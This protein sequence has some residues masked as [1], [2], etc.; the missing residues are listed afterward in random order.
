MDTSPRDEAPRRVLERMRMRLL[1]L[2][3]RNPLLNYTHPRASS[4][5]IVD[6][7]PTVVLD[8]LIANRTYRFAPLKL[9]DAPAPINDPAP[10]GFVRANGGR[11]GRSAN[12]VNTPPNATTAAVATPPPGVEIQPPVTERERR[13][14][15]R[16]ARAQREEQIRAGATAL[17][18][19]PSYDLLAAPASDATRH[20]D[21]R[22]Q[23]LLTPDELE[24]RLQKM[25]A[26]AVTAIQ[27]SGANMLHLLF[28]FVEW[29]DVAGEKTRMAPL[30][31]LP[32]TMSR[33]ALDPATHTYPYTVAASG[34]DWST[35]VT[36]Q[37]MC[38]KSFGFAL[39]S[40]EP[41]EDL[42]QYFSRVEE[43][44]RVAAPQWTL[45]RQLTLGLVSFGKILM[46]RDLDP[47][48]WP[49]DKDILGVPLLRQ[50]LGD[51]DPASEHEEDTPAEL[52]ATEYNID[53]L[54][55]DR[56]PVPPIV[57][58]ADSSQHSVL[59][60][61]QR[62]ENLVVQGPPGTGKSQ[63]ITN[64]IA[65]AIALGKKVLF[66]AEKKAALDVVARRLED[67]GLGPF[68]L[69]LHSH[70][71][72]KREFLDLLKARIDLPA[73]DG[74]ANE[75][76][77]VDGLLAESR[78]ELTGHVERLHRPFGSL[79]LTAFD[80]LWRAR[81][82][83]GEIPE[84]AV[85]TLRDAA[86]ANAKMVTP[87]EAAK[88]RATLQAFAAAH[89]AVA[90]DLGADGVH[91]WQ[92]MSR[93]DLSF[94]AAQSL[95]ALARLAREALEGAERA[96]R[97][98]ASDVPNVAWPDS[99]EA[100]LPLL[101]RVRH[102]VP[103]DA[104][105]PAAVIDAIHA[106]AGES[107]TEAAV[108]A[109]DANR[110]AWNAVEGAWGESGAITPDAATQ[111]TA[112]LRDAMRMLGDEARVGTVREAVGLL[113]EVLDHLLAV[114]AVATRIAAALGVTHELPVGVALG[115]VSVA[116]A[117]E[118][119]PNGALSLRNV[120]LQAPNAAD[121]VASLSQRAAELTRIRALRDARFNPE[122]RPSLAELRRIATAL[123][124]APRFMPGVFSGSYRDAVA[125]Y[126]RMSGGRQADRATMM[127][128]VESLVRFQS[129]YQ[130]FM[131]DPNLETYFGSAARGVDT[132]FE[133]GMAVL[134]WARHATVMF[135][136][137]SRASQALTDA[138][139]N[140]SPQ[141][142]REASE[143][144][145]TNPEGRHAATVLGD[146]LSAVVRFKPGD[147]AL[148]DPLPFQI[149]EDQLHRWRD[150]ALGGVRAAT[151]AGAAP[152]DSLA[153]LSARLTALR[154]AWETDAALASH[155][156]TFRQLGIESLNRGQTPGAKP[157]SSDP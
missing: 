103:P 19:D 67:A 89:A 27:E 11:N 125:A 41:E 132:P 115:L 148:W 112:A 100:L 88:H 10:R 57:V 71:S 127:A 48:T 7:V 155:A 130:V 63:T 51:V 16:A 141:A 101:A 65:D 75:L 13:E 134:D 25:Q 66:V 99:P 144:A 139:W 145:L 136:G 38:R 28:G 8:A 128:D 118:R 109:A 124:E 94:D 80:V 150:I 152:T 83:G 40:V 54:P 30:V 133:S 114:Q 108:Q 4:L 95:V 70:T 9:A 143:L 64:M 34:E 78:K 76:M 12:A 23:T 107:A 135:R 123:A 90:A 43:V 59:V 35:N 116:M 74:A 56:R 121:R 62:G 142:W 68:I 120:A 117:V 138:V 131:S 93:A 151:S 61:V 119:L 140:A 55:A 49:V 39:P 149:I 36:L 3:A 37:E 91:P 96:R 79:G 69:P 46:W 50:V 113:S 2:T 87:S 98:L 157:T 29:S 156:E 72:N 77:T 92:G 15:A 147:I 52:R 106:R 137:T 102:V 32:V 110:L 122:M 45:R 26:S 86:I 42:E 82:L 105:V 22:L 73:T 17:G 97:A 53:A 31:L 18:I 5:R 153:S 60:D 6:E 129:D 14:A 24:A 84:R 126:R 81:R 146:D 104:D 47:A 85:E 20:G 154:R 111:H 58:P 44:L 21:S 1:D 33:L